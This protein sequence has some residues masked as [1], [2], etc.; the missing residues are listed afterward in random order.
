MYQK[1]K[2][3][4]ASMLVAIAVFLFGNKVFGEIQTK[5]GIEPL[6]GV[7]DNEAANPITKPLFETLLSPI[8]WVPLAFLITVLVGTF[9][10]L[11]RRRT[12]NAQ[13]DSEDRQT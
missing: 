3:A 11:K 9:V 8:V 13:K 10:F 7:P 6:Y 1:F 4:Y 12:K 5:Y 2:N